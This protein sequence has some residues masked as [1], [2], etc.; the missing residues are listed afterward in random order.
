MAISLNNNGNIFTC[1]ILGCHD[2]VCGKSNGCGSFLRY[3]RI[4]DL[5]RVDPIT[6]L[7]LHVFYGRKHMIDS[8]INKFTEHFNNGANLEEDGIEYMKKII[9]E[10]H[11]LDSTWKTCPKC[12]E[13]YNN[14]SRKFEDIFYTVPS[15]EFCVDHTT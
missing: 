15:V 10:M 5:D 13:Q 9:L 14:Q 8:L 11:E 3:E 2:T 4:F 12:K 7:F 6:R 1:T